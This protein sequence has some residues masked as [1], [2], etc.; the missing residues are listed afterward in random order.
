MRIIF[1]IC[2][3][4]CLLNLCSFG[5]ERSKRLNFVLLIDNEIPVASISKGIFEIKDSAGYMIDTIPFVYNVG[6]LEVSE[7]DYRLLFSRNRKSTVFIK[8][9][10]ISAMTSFDPYLYKTSI[11]LSK[12]Y[13]IMRI[14]NR[15]KRENVEKYEFGK[16]QYLIQ[17]ETPF[18]TTLLRERTDHHKR[19]KRKIKN[20]HLHFGKGDA[21]Y[22]KVN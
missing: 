10:Y 16:R 1:I 17:T 9:F 7:S 8:F 15:A 18:Y 12:D 21:K 11:A 6:G 2:C 14:F 13:V 19:Y 3:V 5:Q 4:F 22:F 20:K